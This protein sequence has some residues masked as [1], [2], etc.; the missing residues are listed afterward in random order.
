MGFDPS[1]DFGD[2]NT[3]CEALDSY[4]PIG[5]MGMDMDLNSFNDGYSGA[6]DGANG[7]GAGGGHG[8]D[9]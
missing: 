8:V 3:A 9:M 2:L 4:N 7:N 6:G 5:D 1:A